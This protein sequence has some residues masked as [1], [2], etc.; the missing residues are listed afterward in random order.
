MWKPIATAPKDNKRALYLA[1]FDSDG[2]LQ[3]LDFDGIGEHWQESWEMPHIQGRDWCS[4][5]GIVEPTH[6]AYQDEPLPLLPSEALQSAFNRGAEEAHAE[7]EQVA[8]VGTGEPPNMLGEPL[9]RRK[10][11]S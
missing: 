2:K 11:K 8:I 4:A 3:E 5:N 9:Y 10:E 1:R 6:W 7:Y